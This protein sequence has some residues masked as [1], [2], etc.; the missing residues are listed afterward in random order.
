[1]AT[2]SDHNF[3]P[4]ITLNAYMQQYLFNGDLDQLITTLDAQWNKVVRRINETA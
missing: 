2:Y 4:A 3:P 1:M